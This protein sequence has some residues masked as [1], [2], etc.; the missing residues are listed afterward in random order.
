MVRNQI[1]TL[2]M[3]TKY[4]RTPI[5]D[6]PVDWEVLKLKQIAD[7]RRGASPRP[8]GDPKYFGDGPGWVRISD[9][10]R[11]VKY[12]RKTEQQLSE[13][14]VKCS[15]SVKPG[16]II[17]SI[18]ATIGKPIIVDMN[19]CI[20]DGFVLFENLSKDISKDYLYYYLQSYE[21]TFS[22]QGQPGSQKNINTSI[23]GDSYIP[24]PKYGE[25]VKI[26]TILA[27]IDSVLE[28]S[29]AVIEKTK[30]LKK[31]LMQQLLTR[32]IGHKE[33]KNTPIGKIPKEWKVMQLEEVSDIYGGGTPDRTNIKYWDGNIS[34]ATPTDITSLKTNH[35]NTT[36]ERI[37][38]EGLKNSSATLI[39]EGG[40]LMTSR[41]TIGYC[42]I[43][44][45]PMTTNQG[46]ANFVCHKEMNNQFLVYLLTAIR[47]KIE[48][49]GAGSTFM[50]VSK[51][52]LKKLLIQVP[53][54]PEQEEI[55]RII[56]SLDE[57]IEKENIYH[58]SVLQLKSTLMQLLLT[59]RIRV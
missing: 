3:E 45:V 52:A 31:G 25:Q 43:N 19:A 50:E 23:V 12:L 15:V 32:G 22:N 46:F 47:T 39:Q 34:W 56:S 42:A 27:S 2:N 16:D 13:I 33:F 14:G 1:S 37:S 58:Q 7:V 29:S 18:C 55:V 54:I 53:S 57:S 35:I 28:I 20:H 38:E 44:T 9:I 30:Q 41:A 6:L 59:G 21:N 26:G 17:M 24:V 4:K 8:I 11:S 10:T 48:R 5:G 36:K 51:S 49:L 40:V